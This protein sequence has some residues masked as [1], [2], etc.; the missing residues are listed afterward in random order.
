M[1]TSTAVQRD[2]QT[3]AGTPP[4]PV[5][6]SRQLTI[7]GGKPFGPSAVVLITPA[8]EAALKTPQPDVHVLLHFHGITGGYGDAG[9][10]RS[11]WDQIGPQLEGTGRK[12]IAVLPQAGKRMEGKGW[13]FGRAVSKPSEYLAEVL[14]KLQVQE[15]WADVPKYSVALSG[16][17][18]GGFQAAQALSRGLKP[19][20]VV[21]FDGIN[22]WIELRS[23]ITWVTSELD[24]ALAQLK[25]A[26]GDPQKEEEVLAR[27]MMF[28]A[29]HSGA[30][31]DP[32]KDK[33]DL[34][35]ELGKNKDAI[36]NRGYAGRHAILK[37]RID[38]WFATNGAQLSEG[39][40]ARLQH[41]FLV[42]GTP[43]SGHEPVVG[44]S[45]GLEKGL[46]RKMDEPGSRDL[47]RQPAPVT[48][49]PV[50]PVKKQWADDWADPAFA[51]AR[52]WFAE[53][54]R[55]D[56]TAEE[57]YYK[58]C[59]MYKAHENILRPLKYIADNIKEDFSFFQ[60]TTS[61][62]SDLATKLG[63]A[64][65]KL[66]EDKQWTTAP[67][68]SA[69]ALTVRTTSEGTWSNH[70]TGTAIDLD[71][72]TNPRFT[73]PA[74]RKVIKALTGYDI[75]LAN[76]GA[77]SG[78]DSYDA[79]LA[80]STALEESYN[81]AGTTARID[82]LATSEAAL[83][84][85]RDLIQKE[86]VLVVTGK[87]ATNADRQSLK[88]ITARLNAKKAALKGVTGE[89]AILKQQL[90]GYETVDAAIAALV[91]ALATK[92]EHVKTL[93]AAVAVADARTKTT[94]SA[95]LNAERKAFA[96]AQK[97]LQVKEAA[98]DGQRLR[99]F[100]STGFLNLDK[101]LVVALKAA[102]LVWGGDWAGSKDYMHFQTP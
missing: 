94:L 91:D 55:P 21:L 69:W 30:D 14:A 77:A 76:P 43:G 33:V 84:A 82:E 20:E 13:G 52:R 100:A 56:G 90:T 58:L 46:A 102:G 24:S 25:A 6:A 29:Y 83:V 89:V 62:H 38:H 79:S 53:K 5:A 19:K 49:T 65:K 22:G 66:K 97:R 15:K 32:V 93:E 27:G 92:D 59:P 2:Q 4:T 50:D 68:V 88:A 99:K 40:R 61:G 9:K 7:A 85:E 63:V 73:K 28:R 86:L 12:M 11:A 87:R 71:P 26:A 54:G 72:D 48:A 96:L 42:V 36:G 41:N 98:R 35:M 64:E 70:A 81:P 10:E 60:F 51:R 78:L 67:L 23:M 57:R 31:L 74:E 101:D 1:R 3:V 18:G 95:A 17:S 45:H 16:H 39:V 75:A 34:S 44:K 8:A 47:R 80:A 37:Y